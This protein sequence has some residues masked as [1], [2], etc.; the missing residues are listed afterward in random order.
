M[1]CSG[2]TGYG[3]TIRAARNLAAAAT[4]SPVVLI[5]QDNAGDDQPA[6]EIQQ[7]AG[8]AWIKFSGANA[9][10]ADKTEANEYLQVETAAGT[11]YLRLYT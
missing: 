9:I 10:V 5:I 8:A 11:R 2:N 7:D 4:G 3:H 6:L 1:L